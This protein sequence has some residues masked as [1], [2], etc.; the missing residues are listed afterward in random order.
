MNAQKTFSFE[1][2]L[3]L[4]I[5]SYLI[6]LIV[7]TLGELSNRFRM[8]KLKNTMDETKIQGS[9]QLPIS[10]PSI[11]MSFYS[12]RCWTHQ[13]NMRRIESLVA[14]VGVVVHLRLEEQRDDQDGGSQDTDRA[15]TKNIKFFLL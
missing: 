11:V 15:G 10:G 6:S 8:S 3:L 14:D 5:Q 13:H 12:D 1:N 9:L 4:S 7:M 2:F